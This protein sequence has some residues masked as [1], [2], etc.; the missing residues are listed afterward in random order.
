MLGSCDACVFGAA[1]AWTSVVALAH[2]RLSPTLVT[3]LQWL[4][5]SHHSCWSTGSVCVGQA[6]I[7]KQGE[8]TDRDNRREE[9]KWQ[10]KRRGRQRDKR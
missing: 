9:A 6:V 3:S 7:R 1:C 10:A 4:C 5:I 8:T 2:S